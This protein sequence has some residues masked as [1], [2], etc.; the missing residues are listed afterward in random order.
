MRSNTFCYVVMFLLVGIAIN[1][2]A[3]QGPVLGNQAKLSM[4]T[5]SKERAPLA[6][7]A[8]LEDARAQLGR[9]LNS[10]ETKSDIKLGAKAKLAARQSAKLRK[11]DEQVEIA[12]SDDARAQLGE[13][14]S[15]QKKHT[16]GI[17]K[18][19]SARDSR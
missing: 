6:A 7:P 12:V 1:C 8:A 9:E 16:F 18:K 14:K 3:E 2:G 11:A 13:I 17:N 19:L 15:E 10:E 5:A 4:R